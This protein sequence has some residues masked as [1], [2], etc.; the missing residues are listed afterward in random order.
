MNYPVL[1]LI[2]DTAFKEKLVLIEADLLSSSSPCTIIE[3]EGQIE[4]PCELILHIT[5]RTNL[6]S[7]RW[8]RQF[9]CA[10]VY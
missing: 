5:L 7:F 10:A 3:W 6:V 8:G 2:D 1:L 4:A 9:P